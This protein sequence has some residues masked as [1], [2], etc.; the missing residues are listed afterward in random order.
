MI[1]R[2]GRVYTKGRREVE[3]RLPVAISEIG[4]SGRLR[5]K[6]SASEGQQVEDRA[7]WPFLLEGYSH[8]QADPVFQQH[9]V[10]LVEGHARV[11]ENL[12]GAFAALF[13]DMFD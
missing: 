6:A 13:L 10:V 2:S 7:C 4:S 9:L 5:R 8:T 11:G 12:V 3:F 1:K